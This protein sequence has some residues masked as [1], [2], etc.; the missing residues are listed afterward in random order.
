MSSGKREKI[1]SNKSEFRVAWS[2]LYREQIL[3]Q[4]KFRKVSLGK[5]IKLS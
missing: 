5:L 4:E 2:D 1:E 3:R